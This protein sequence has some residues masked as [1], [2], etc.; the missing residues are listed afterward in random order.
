MD[1]R[2]KALNYCFLGDSITDYY[3]RNTDIITNCFQVGDLTYNNSTPQ[4]NIVRK[5]FFSK[6]LGSMSLRR[7]LGKRAFNYP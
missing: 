6:F 4:W 1:D 5:R 7:H 3:L 2:Q